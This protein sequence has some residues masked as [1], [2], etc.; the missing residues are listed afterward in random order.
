MRQSVVGLAVAVIYL[1]PVVVSGNFLPRGLNGLVRAA[2]GIFRP[3]GSRARNAATMLAL[4]RASTTTTTT[5]VAPIPARLDSAGSSINAQ[6]M[7]QYLGM[8]KSSSFDPSDLLGQLAISFDKQNA[9]GQHTSSSDDV[10]AQVSG[11]L[12]MLLSI[13]KPVMGSYKGT[14]GYEGLMVN[15]NLSMRNMAFQCHYTELDYSKSHHTAL[16]DTISHHFTY[17]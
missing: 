9:E 7:T 3:A 12:P 4:M 10:V 5:T 1:V 11:M 2:Q 15:V 6:D 17:N 13:A 8:P 14:D 16:H